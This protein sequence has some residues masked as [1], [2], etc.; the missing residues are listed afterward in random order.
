M[1]HAFRDVARDFTIVSV[2][3]CLLYFEIDLKKAD[4]ESDVFILSSKACE[5][6]HFGSY[7]FHVICR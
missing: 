3:Y 2:I 1:L 6:L 5:R 4:L 7:Y